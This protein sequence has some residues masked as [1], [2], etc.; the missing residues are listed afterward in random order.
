VTFSTPTRDYTQTPT[1]R[2]FECNRDVT[3]DDRISLETRRNGIHDEVCAEL[4]PATIS[5]HEY[6]AM[7]MNNFGNDLLI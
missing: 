6:S 3:T 7:P 1:G 2:D 5:D 4:A